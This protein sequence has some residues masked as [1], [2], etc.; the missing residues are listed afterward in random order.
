MSLNRP[1]VKSSTSM[2]LLDLVKADQPEADKATVKAA[3]KQMAAR[4]LVVDTSKDKL[5]VPNAFIYDYDSDNDGTG[6]RFDGHNY[7]YHVVND[8][9]EADPR[10]VAHRFGANKR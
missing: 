5:Q 2:S 8:R 1:L 6:H 10:Y 3:A 4:S 9:E 7:G